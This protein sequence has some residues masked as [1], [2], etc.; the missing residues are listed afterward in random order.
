MEDYK[1]CQKTRYK[2][3]HAHK[4]AAHMDKSSGSEVSLLPGRWTW[5]LIPDPLLKMVMANE[6][7]AMV[8]TSSAG[9]I[10]H[11]NVAKFDS[12]PSKVGIDNRFS[13][14]ISHDVNDF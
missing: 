11:E 3:R 8:Y 12:D 13:A 9:E 1:L 7:V 10:I 4:L 6:V 5:K 2:L 14:C